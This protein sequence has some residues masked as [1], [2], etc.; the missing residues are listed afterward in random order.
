MSD[1][2]PLDERHRRLE[3]LIALQLEITK[4]INS[5]QAGHTIEIL[6]ERQSRRKTKELMGRTRNHKV[7][8]FP[9]DAKLVGKLVHVKVKSVRGR[10]A[11]GE[12][13]SDDQEGINRGAAYRRGVCSS[14]S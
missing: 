13:I 10:T 5:R 7:V 11:W 14:T 2:V 9:G 4:K 12:I 6:V 3:Q 1:Q 8:I